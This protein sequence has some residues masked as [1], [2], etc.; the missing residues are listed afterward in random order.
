MPKVKAGQLWRH[1]KGGLYR[2]LHAALRESDLAEAVVYVAARG[3]L[4][5]TVW[6]R[7]LSEWLEEV[8][9]G[10]ERYTLVVEGVLR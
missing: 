7:P 5:P 9:P 6:V 2:V 10:V 3:D 8:S 4:L 1:Y